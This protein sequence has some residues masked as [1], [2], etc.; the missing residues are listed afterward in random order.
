VWDAVETGEVMSLHKDDYPLEL[1]GQARV[2]LTKWY[3]AKG[4]KDA[5]LE[6]KVTRVMRVQFPAAAEIIEK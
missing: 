6:D 2:A 3:E 5:A 4:L 1:L